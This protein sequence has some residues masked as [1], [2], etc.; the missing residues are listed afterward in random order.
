MVCNCRNDF[1]MLLLH[2]NLNKEKVMKK[3]FTIIEVMVLVF[4]LFLVGTYVGNA[5]RFFS[6]NFEAPYK[7]EIAYGI[8]V[9]VV[10][11]FPVT[12]FMSIED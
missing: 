6:C 4:I 5:V 8:G 1:S 3:G 7:A 11:S 10:P 12:A 2:N 9:L